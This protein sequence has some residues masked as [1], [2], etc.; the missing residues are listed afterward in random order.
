MQ[1]RRSSAAP[2]QPARRR[3]AHV[4]PRTLEPACDAA[5]PSMM[6]PTEAPPNATSSLTHARARGRAASTR[7]RSRV[8]KPGSAKPGIDAERTCVC[9]AI[10]RKRHAEWMRHVRSETM[11]IMGAIKQ[12]QQDSLCGRGK[13]HQHAPTHN[14]SSGSSPIKAHQRPFNKITRRDTTYLPTKSRRKTHLRN[15][16]KTLARAARQHTPTTTRLLPQGRHGVA[17]RRSAGGMLSK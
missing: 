9:C 5:P 12:L 17:K 1:C 6:D 3:V 10:T 15:T 4:H 13:H 2:L 14:A 7:G 16:P 11:S 8:S